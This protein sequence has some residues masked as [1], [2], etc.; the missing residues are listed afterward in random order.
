VERS[1]SGIFTVL[2]AQNTAS[3]LSAT[4]FTNTGTFDV[5]GDSFGTGHAS[6]TFGGPAPSTVTG[7]IRVLGNASLQ[8][9]GGG[10]INSIASG[11][12][13]ELD[14]WRGSHPC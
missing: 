7:N 11:A 2:A 10:T 12:T 8:F 4:G 6:A 1:N 13:L 9:T 14:T 3:T 5:L